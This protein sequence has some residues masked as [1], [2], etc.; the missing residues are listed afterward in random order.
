MRRGAVFNGVCDFL[1]AGCQGGEG[2][3]VVCTALLAIFRVKEGIKWV[4]LTDSS[5][6]IFWIGYGYAFCFLRISLVQNTV[7]K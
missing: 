3:G 4:T 2:G 6:L 5:R 7:H 1:S